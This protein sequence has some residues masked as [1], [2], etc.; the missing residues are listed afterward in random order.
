MTLEFSVYALIRV[1][2][3]NHMVNVVHQ[4]KILFILALYFLFYT[5]RTALMNIWKELNLAQMILMI[6]F[7]VF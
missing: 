3:W 4:N 1:D 6:I 5:E 7:L 2:S